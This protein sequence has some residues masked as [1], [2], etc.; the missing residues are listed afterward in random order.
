MT[1]PIG[2]PK[3]LHNSGENARSFAAKVGF[4]DAN[5]ADFD[6]ERKNDF[7]TRPPT[8]AGTRGTRAAM[9]GLP[10]KFTPGHDR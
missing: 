5:P 8:C 1:V 6:C 4:E 9:I 2:R 7:V 10:I 3:R